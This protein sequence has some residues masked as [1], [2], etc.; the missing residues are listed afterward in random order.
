MP[1]NDSATANVFLTG[2]ITQ[3]KAMADSTCLGVFYWEPQSYG[4][5]KGYD[6][7]AFDETGAPT[8]A[9]DAFKRK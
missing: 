3:S 4:N 1:W 9:L 6:K 8:E 2:L 7:G 5:W